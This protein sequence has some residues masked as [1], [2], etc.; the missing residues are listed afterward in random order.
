MKHRRSDGR[1][2]RELEQP[3]VR[4]QDVTVGQLITE[5]SAK[6]GEKIYVRLFV[7]YALGD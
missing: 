1:S 5:V 4:N 3:F 7:R 2:G 6:T